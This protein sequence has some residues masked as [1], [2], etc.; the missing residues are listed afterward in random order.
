MDQWACEPFPSLV[1]RRYPRAQPGVVVPSGTLF[2]DVACARIKAELLGKFNLHTII[3]LPNGVS[4]PST[5]SRNGTKWGQATL[6]RRPPRP[7]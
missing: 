2:G 3:R 4:A 6:I 7:A 5:S 1:Q